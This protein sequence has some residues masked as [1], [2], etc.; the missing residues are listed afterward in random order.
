VKYGPLAGLEGILLRKRDSFRLV[1]SIDII[2]RSVAVEID[3]ADI[4]SAR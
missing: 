4:E 1:L 3:A 2:M